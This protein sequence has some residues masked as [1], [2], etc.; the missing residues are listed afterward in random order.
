M[1]AN[2]PLHLAIA[3]NDAG[4]HP[5]AWR[6]PDARPSELFSARYWA[7][8]V[9]EAERGLVDFV[10]IEDSLGVQSGDYHSADDRTDQVRGRLDAVLIAA[11]VAAV[12]RTIGLV[13]TGVVTHTEP[14][15]L[16]KA[17]ATL[18]YASTGRAG[19]RIQVTARGFEAD[20]FGRRTF[21]PFRLEDFETPEVQAL[22][23]ELFDEAV[24]YVEVLRRLWDSW[25]DDA[26]IR[27]AATGRF[28]DRHKLHYIDFEGAHFSVKGP[29]IT[30]RPPQGQPLVT[31]L[32]HATVPYRLIARAADVGFVTPRYADQA[33]E[34]VE[35]IRHEQELAGRAAERLHIFGDV[36]VFLDETEAA[37]RDRRARLDAVAGSELTSDAHIFAGTPA[38]LADLLADWHRAGLSGF[39]LRPATV[40]HDLEQI[41]RGLVP[42][43]QRRGLFRRSYEA[44]TLRGLLGLERPANRYASAAVSTTVSP[45]VSPSVSASVSA[46]EPAAEAAD[47]S[48]AIA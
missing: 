31:A 10:T 24:D 1:P 30:P 47:S 6:E 7:D 16:S 5:A 8:Q 46:G 12:T 44:D 43:L 27:D 41:T 34:I 2:A 22:T 21:P 11:R 37:A 25:E 3:L 48:F 4:W 39:R 13:A 40:P 18:D 19:I 38:Q 20:L 32:G 17:I 45:S 23:A 28:I 33:A 35:E 14:F 36:L 15:H 26:E 29:S 9:A 42:E